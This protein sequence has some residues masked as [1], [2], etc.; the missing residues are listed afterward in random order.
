MISAEENQAAKLVRSQQVNYSNGLGWSDISNSTTFDSP[1]MTRFG[2]L[3][4]AS[5]AQA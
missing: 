4:V 2:Q 3:L 1:V 5:S